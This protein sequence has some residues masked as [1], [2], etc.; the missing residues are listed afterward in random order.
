MADSASDSTAAAPALKEIFNRERLRHFAAETAA[1]WP[2]FDQKRFMKLATAGLDELGI[3]QRMRQT[4]VSL[5]E[6]LPEEFPEGAAD[7]RKTRAAHRPRFC[8]DHAFRIR[9]ALRPEPFRSVARR[10]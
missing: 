7:P 2:G 6:T 4:A 1:I 9:R 10:R 3:M 8:G 5:H